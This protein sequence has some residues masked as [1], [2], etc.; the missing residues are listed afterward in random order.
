MTS[1]R[2]DT[3]RGFAD[4]YDLH[5]W[6]WYAGTYGPRLFEMLEKRRLTDGSHPPRVLD[7]GCGTG[8]LALAMAARGW[9]VTGLDL[10]EAMLSAAR[11][12]DREGRVTWRRGDIT[13]FDLNDI[14]RDG[15]FDLIT[16]VADT[17]NHLETLDEWEAAFRRC[18]AHLASGGSLF[19]D[20]MTCLGLARLDKFT[21]LD[22]D[23]RALILGIIYE[24]GSRR[25]TVKVTS[26]VP[27]ERSSG[28]YEKAVETV[29]E[30]GHPVAGILE[31]LD[32]AGFTDAERLWPGGEPEAEERLSIIARRR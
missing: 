19:F 28:L 8:T 12:K 29:T 10:S 16:T 4:H 25:S 24:P 17:L 22:Q 21:V 5:A 18:A 9:R 32:R 14:T 2:L 6:D 23:D 26:F 13:A 7:A 20:V 30:W 15:P 27:A 1:E 11:R 31:R 3:Y